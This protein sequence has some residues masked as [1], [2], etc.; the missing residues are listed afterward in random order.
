M[1]EERNPRRVEAS[2]A[3]HG[4]EKITP[5]TSKEDRTMETMERAVEMLE[6]K[7]D[8]EEAHDD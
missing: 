1:D 4:V 6:S 7:A 8:P 2:S 3:A 5:L